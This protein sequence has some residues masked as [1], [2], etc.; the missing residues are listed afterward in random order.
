[1]RTQI[2]SIQLL[3][4]SVSTE[5][6]KNKTVLYE[7]CNPYINYDLIGIQSSPPYHLLYHCGYPNIIIPSY[8]QGGYSFTEMTQISY[9]GNETDLNK[10]IGVYSYFDYIVFDLGLDIKSH[11]AY[12]YLSA[13]VSAFLETGKFKFVYLK[14]KCRS[15]TSKNFEDFVT[16]LVAN[17]VNG[18]LLSEFGYT[19]GLTREEQNIYLEIAIR[20]NLDVLIEGYYPDEYFSPDVDVN[21]NPDGIPTLAQ[22][23]RFGWIYPDCVC[24]TPLY[25]STSNPYGLVSIPDVYQVFERGNFYKLKNGIRTYGL[26]TIVTPT[27]TYSSY[28]SSGELELIESAIRNI[29]LF[30]GLNGYGICT[31]YNSA[32]DNRIYLPTYPTAS[33]CE[34]FAIAPGD[35]SYIS[36]SILSN[37]YSRVHKG[38]S[39]NLHI[40][41]TNQVIVNTTEIEEGKSQRKNNLIVNGGFRSVNG[42]IIPYWELVNVTAAQSSTTVPYAGSKSLQVTFSTTLPSYFQQQLEFDS[43]FSDCSFILTFQSFIPSSNT[44]QIQLQILSGSQTLSYTLQNT[45]SI[46]KYQNIHFTVTSVTSPL[47]IRV[48]AITTTSTPVSCYFTDFVLERITTLNRYLP[49]TNEKYSRVTNYV[50]INTSNQ[51]TIYPN[52]CLKQEFGQI[53]RTLTQNTNYTISVNLSTTFSSIY[54]IFYS[55]ESAVLT[56]AQPV[57]YTISKTTSSFS[58]RVRTAI[59]GTYIIHYCVIGV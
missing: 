22:G 3:D 49:H 25:K 10:L 41:T 29:S 16:M 5:D 15:Y 59:T 58:F 27:Q 45:N 54:S 1:M 23:S 6:I 57:C 26:N 51:Y 35:R 17:H 28:D 55:I 21:Y 14:Y 53:S 50:S 52:P 32:A 11:T 38:L 2:R 56:T 13:I 7:D 48:A 31:L 9:W 37:T 40:T 46:W 36:G 12:P 34:H 47:T 19:E 24:N 42:S 30:F 20:N 39:I 44:Q 18:V 4:D 43:S 33:L 8:L